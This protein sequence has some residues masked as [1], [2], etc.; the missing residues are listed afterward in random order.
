MLKAESDDIE[1]AGDEEKSMAK[2]LDKFDA[3]S[4]SLFDWLFGV[5][6]MKSSACEFVLRSYVVLFRLG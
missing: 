4:E 5:C 6:F 2:L 3:D 1:V